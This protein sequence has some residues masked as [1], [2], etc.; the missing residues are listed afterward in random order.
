V[1]SRADDYRDKAR[2]CER[3]AGLAQD[4]S[5]RQI[6]LDLAKQWRD[7]AE[8]IERHGIQ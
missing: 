7:L 3:Q 4:H 5:L 2:D 8:Q 1:K 6:Y